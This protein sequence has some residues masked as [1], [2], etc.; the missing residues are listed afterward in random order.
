VF[1][2]IRYASHGFH[3]LGRE[4]FLAPVTW[5]HDG[6]PVVNE[7]QKVTEQMNVARTIAA[8]PWPNLPTRD[9]FATAALGPQWN[10]LRNPDVANWS[11]SER[12]GWLRLRC[13]ASTLDDLASPAFIGRRQQH[14]E[15]RI[16]TLM[17][18][19]PQ[20]E[21]EEAGLCALI[22]NKD[23][24]ELVITRRVGD[25]VAFVRRRIGSAIV[26]TP[27]LPVTTAGLLTLTLSADRERYCFSLAAPGESPREIG[28][29][30]VRYLSTEVAGGYTGVVI[31]LFATARGKTSN[32]AAHFDWFD[33]Q[34]VGFDAANAQV[35]G[36]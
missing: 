12:P 14:F 18:F 27:P 8:Q 36:S 31:G 9:D 26:E 10:F 13:A 32:A 6:W 33:Y 15:A 2:G 28:R 5:T 11:L 29:H 3:N 30:E 35:A 20:H 7:G 25:R 22:D 21:D 1:L 19:N 16:A 34:P 4:T 17:D 24:A 23:H